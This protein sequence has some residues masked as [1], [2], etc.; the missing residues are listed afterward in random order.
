MAQATE[1]KMPV[2]RHLTGQTGEFL[3]AAELVRSGFSVAVPSGNAV[4][5]DLLAYRNK[6]L[7]AVQV[8]STVGS[9]IQVDMG[10]FLDIK[11]DSDNGQQIIHGPRLDL[12]MNILVVAVFVGKQ[13]GG[14][15]FY[16]AWMRDFASFMAEK[17]GEY[18]TKNGGARPG[19]NK[20]SLHF[21]FSERHSKEDERFQSL[22]EI[23]RAANI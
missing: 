5:F 20:S 9:S 16:C 13:F 4:A 22:V 3:V 18:L 10:K 21:A 1:L 6:R 7:L 15:R 17:H 2:N 19:P 12:D 8:K 14:D 11:T 23:L